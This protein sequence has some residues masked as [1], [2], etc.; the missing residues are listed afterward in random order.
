MQFQFK[1]GPAG[2]LEIW[3]KDESL[4]DRVRAI[5]AGEG[6]MEGKILET[7]DQ[8]YMD[9]NIDQSIL[10]LHWD[11][12]AGLA[13]IAIDQ[14]SEGALRTFGNKLVALGYTCEK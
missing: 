5:L 10:R 14:T 3:F 1:R 8:I 9:F 13:L 12:F 7:P 2:Q 6:G 11:N 4:F